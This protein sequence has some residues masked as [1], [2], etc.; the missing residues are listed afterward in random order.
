M[1]CSD[2]LLLL[3]Q[4]SITFAY[5]QYNFKLYQKNCIFYYNVYWN[6]LS[7]LRLTQD[8]KKSFHEGSILKRNM[9]GYL[10]FK[11]QV[12]YLSI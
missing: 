11:K 9:E 8:T 4:L 12:K 6:T 5:V 10:K 1:I 2:T 7:K 3:K